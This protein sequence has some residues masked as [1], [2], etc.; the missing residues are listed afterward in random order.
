MA[1]IPPIRLLAKD[2]SL[3]PNRRELLERAL[4]ERQARL[5]GP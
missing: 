4:R 1:S 3:D 2:G 5:S